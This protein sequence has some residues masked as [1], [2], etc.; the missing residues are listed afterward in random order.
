ML[1]RRLCEGAIEQ[2]EPL[3]KLFRFNT[4]SAADVNV[5]HILVAASFLQG[6]WLVEATNYFIVHLH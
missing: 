1:D 2:K 4:Y 6:I 3:T 5:K